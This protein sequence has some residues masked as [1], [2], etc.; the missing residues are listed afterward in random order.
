MKY[1]EINFNVMMGKF[2]IKGIRLMVE[3]ILEEMFVGK[4]VDYLISVFF[5]FFKEV[6][7]VVLVL[8]VDVIKG[9]RFYLIVI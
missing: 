1:I 9:E 7:W 2:V 3:L 6:V 8:V 4:E 5:R